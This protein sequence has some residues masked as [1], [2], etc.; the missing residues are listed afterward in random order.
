MVR[1]CRPLVVRSRPTP[2]RLLALLSHLRPA[3]WIED[4]LPTRT[5]VEVV[6]GAPT[7]FSLSEALLAQ[8]HHRVWHLVERARQLPQMI[9]LLRG[10]VR[11][12]RDATAKLDVGFAARMD[13][14]VR[15]GGHDIATCTPRLDE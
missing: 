14:A 2:E 1:G 7:S 11:D 4:L 15:W 3:V 9:P 13:F 6:A 5:G 8:V 12:G 10:D